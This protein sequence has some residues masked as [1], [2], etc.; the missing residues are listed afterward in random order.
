MAVVLFAEDAVRQQNESSAAELLD[1]KDRLRVKFLD[2]DGFRALLQELSDASK[3]KP[4][5]A[6]YQVVIEKARISRD[7]LTTRRQTLARLVGAGL[8]REKGPS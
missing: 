5:P 7:A 4:S 1:A 3:T 2:A 8:L 6:G